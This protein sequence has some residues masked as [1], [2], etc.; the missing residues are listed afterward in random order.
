[1]NSVA[2]EINWPFKQLY[3]EEGYTLDSLG[4]RSGINPTYLSLFA[5]GK[6]NLSRDQLSRLALL[7]NTSVDRLSR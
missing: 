7:L 1:M 3:V 2:G 6:Y 5:R 4:E